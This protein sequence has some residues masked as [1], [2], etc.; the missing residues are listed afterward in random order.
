MP[1]RFSGHW[2]PL[3]S[4]GVL[5]CWASRSDSGELAAVWSAIRDATTHKGHGGVLEEKLICGGTEIATML[6]L[7][8]RPKVDFAS[9]RSIPWASVLQQADNYIDRENGFLSKL[10]QELLDY[11]SKLPDFKPDGIDGKDMLEATRLTPIIV[12]AFKKSFGS[13]PKAGAVGCG[14]QAETAAYTAAEDAFRASIGSALGNKFWVGSSDVEKE[15]RDQLKVE[16]LTVTSNGDSACD[17][18]CTSFGAIAESKSRVPNGGPLE[19]PSLSYSELSARVKAVHSEI[20]KRQQEVRDCAADR[21]KLLDLGKSLAEF[22]TDLD[23]QFKRER[24][25]L[26]KLHKLEKSTAN[27]TS[28]LS[29]EEAKLE[30][31]VNAV[32]KLDGDASKTR[33][34]VSNLLSK[35]K[36]LSERSKIAQT[37]LQG[38]RNGIKATGEAMRAN[39]ELRK[40]TE[41]ALYD[42]VQVYDRSVRQPLRDLGIPEIVQRAEVKNTFP[43]IELLTLRAESLLKK[44]VKNLGDSCNAVA[45][46]VGSLKLSE[47]NITKA[48]VD[49]KASCSFETE[50]RQR[51]IDAAIAS[52]QKR[53]TF[54]KDRLKEL[55]CDTDEWLCVKEDSEADAKARQLKGEPPYLSD[56]KTVYGDSLFYKDFARSWSGAYK[57]EPR[58]T[59]LQLQDALKDAY[60]SLRK[61]EV[62]ARKTYTELTKDY[63]EVVAQRQTMN[64]ELTS[65]LEKERLADE[66]RMEIKKVADEL[67]GSLKQ[68]MD[69]KVLFNKVY[70]ESLEAYDVAKAKMETEFQAYGTD[71][72]ASQNATLNSLLAG[73]EPATSNA[74]NSALSEANFIGGDENSGEEDAEKALKHLDNMLRK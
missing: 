56:V 25:A 28:Q 41:V 69:M 57:E 13:A 39:H 66:H 44:H 72:V 33:K 23:S 71:D 9:I 43:E 70:R 67:E 74:L 18:L 46:K 54:V 5:G 40:A 47:S 68:L 37:Q 52:I 2:W 4:L 73:E 22:Q 16:L 55:H 62:G 7:E 42:L 48:E 10:Q 60:N 30:D 61:Q 63:S 15:C 65:L 31:A 38:L 26:V 21:K 29:N 6:G 11:A 12:D 53:Q 17:E 27:M 51:G 64:K 24:E 3:V 32:S 20:E 34:I 1:G 58:G 8:N 14:I 36:D 59:L 45:E 50:N 19:A 49:L 35:Q